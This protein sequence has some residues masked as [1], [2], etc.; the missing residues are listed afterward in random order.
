MIAKVLDQLFTLQIMGK[1]LLNTFL[2][3]AALNTVTLNQFAK[4]PLLAIH[5]IDHWHRNNALTIADF[6][7]MH[8]SDHDIDDN[9][10]TQDNQLPL[11]SVDF[12]SAPQF[13]TPLST[14]Y[15]TLCEIRIVVKKEVLNKE[16]ALS[17]RLISGLF[18]PPRP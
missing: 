14:I 9:D 17:S 2:I 5:Y 8:Y 6:L 1:I 7:S 16:E 10:D 11:K 3:I 4:L 18:R 13:A 12:S 15:I